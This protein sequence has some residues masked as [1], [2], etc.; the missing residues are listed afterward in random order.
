MLFRILLPL[1]Q[2]LL[3]WPL[4][5]QVY[6]VNELIEFITPYSEYKTCTSIQ[7]L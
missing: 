2:I 7:F 4:S 5:Y 1:P 3:S 6:V